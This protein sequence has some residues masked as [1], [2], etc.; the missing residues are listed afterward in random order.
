MADMNAEGFMQ[1]VDSAQQVR[2]H[3]RPVLSSRPRVRRRRQRD[4]ALRLRQEHAGP[5]RRRPRHLG[6]RA[7]EHLHAAERPVVQHQPARASVRERLRHPLRRPQR[8]V[9]LPGRRGRRI[10][11]ARRARHERPVPRPRSANV[12]RPVGHH[13]EPALPRDR[14]GAASRNAAS[15]WTSTPIRACSSPT[16]RTTTRSSRIPTSCNS[17]AR[18]ATASSS[19]GSSVTTRTNARRNRAC[20]R[21][22]AYRSRATCS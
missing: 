12:R 21:S 4:P 6:D 7:E 19:T 1:S 18:T 3:Q 22:E 9:G 2:R 11:D 10:R 20:R 17:A 8:R 14:R 5:A 15:W 16:A 13:R